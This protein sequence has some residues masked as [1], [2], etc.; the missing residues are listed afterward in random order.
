MKLKAWVSSLFLI[1]DFYRA[2]DFFIR[3]IWVVSESQKACHRTLRDQLQLP[4]NSQMP[5]MECLPLYAAL[6][7][8]QQMRIWDSPKP[9][10]RRVIL[11]TNIGKSFIRKTSED[12]SDHEKDED[13]YFL[14][15]L[16]DKD[17]RN[18]NRLHRSTAK[19]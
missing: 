10:K 4:G 1:P 2:M 17:I 14:D 7:P 19:I 16:G 3:F 11:S 13:D 5:K 9:G 18:K 12:S 15:V 8:Q 6:S